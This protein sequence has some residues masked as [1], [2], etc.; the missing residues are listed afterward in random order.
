MISVETRKHL[1]GMV[2]EDGRSVAA[3][4]RDLRISA[5]SAKRFLRYFFDTGGDFHYD[6]VQWNRHFD[7]SADD[8]QLRDA[9]LSTVRRE[10]ELFLDEMADALNDFATQVDLAVEA[11][12]ATLARVLGRKGYMRK[13][14]ERAF[15]TRNDANRVAWVAAQWRIPLPCSVYVD[16]A[17]RVGRAVERR[18][19]WLL[20]GARSE[21][22][23]TSSPGV[24]TSFLVAILH[25]ELLDWIITR[26]RP[27]Q[28]SVDFL[29]F[30]TN[31]VL[32]R[33]SVVEDG[34]E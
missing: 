27:G 15:I 6:P 28:A 13:I 12:P 1:V 33:M 24:R 20:R 11:S 23:V 29:L 18:W 19:A 22:Y 3:A 26:P 31:I 14:V 2:R 25:D 8:P 5:R 10:P 34:G 7:K 32:P 16:E 9:A 17:N 4:A 30:M 21:S